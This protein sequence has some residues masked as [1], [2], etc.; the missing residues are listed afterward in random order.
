[1]ILMRVEISELTLENDFSSFHKESTFWAEVL[2]DAEC[3]KIRL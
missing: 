2:L 1:M 3:R